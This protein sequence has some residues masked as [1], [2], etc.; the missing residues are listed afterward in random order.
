MSTE[1]KITKEAVLAAA[2]KC[3]TAKA[4]LETL[5]PEVF[6]S[7][8][9]RLLP[10]NFII[11]SPDGRVVVRN[12]LYDKLNADHL[13]LGSSFNFELVQD[14]ANAYLKVTPK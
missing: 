11:Q 3:S 12:S 2:A 1:L 6:A 4:T 13:Y 10:E 5:F 14:S 8:T 9:K 7:S